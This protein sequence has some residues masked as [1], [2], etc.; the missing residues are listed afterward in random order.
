VCFNIFPLIIS[1]INR[2]QVYKVWEKSATSVLIVL[3]K[4]C[5]FDFDALISVQLLL[6]KCEKKLADDAKKK[7]EEK[8]EEE[9][10][11]NGETKVGDKYRTGSSEA[12]GEDNTKANDEKSTPEK[13][14]NEEGNENSSSSILSGNE[15]ALSTVASSTDAPGSGVASDVDNANATGANNSTTHDNIHNVNPA[16]SGSTANPASQI[17]KKFQ[18]F[19][20]LVIDPSILSGKGKNIGA[21][22]RS[23]WYTDNWGKVIFP[24]EYDAQAYVV[25]EVARSDE[26]VQ[27]VSVDMG[28]VESGVGIT[29]GE[30]GSQEGSG[31]PTSQGK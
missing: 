14:T 19:L 31:S 6:K 17:E 5:I 21:L 9:A 25:Q 26:K 15:K 13:S 11:I 12:K 29:I 2:F 22:T 20:L 8:A 7:A 28:A 30:E 18:K 23:K 1:T 4:S 10:A 27:A 16:V 3:Q 24:S